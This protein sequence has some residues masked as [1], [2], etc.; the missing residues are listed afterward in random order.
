M[1]NKNI[2]LIITGGIAAYKS[3]DLIRRL[4]DAGANVRCI[5]TR[6]GAEFITPLSVASL[7]GHPVYSDLFS[8][9][10]EVEMGH[11]RLSRE[12]DLIIVA[13]ATAETIAKIAMGRADDLATT[14][15]LAANKPILIVP[16][17]NAQMWSNAATQSNIAQLR[18]RGIHQLGPNSG[19]LACGEIGD[20]RMAEVSEIMGWC[21]DY[22][23]HAGLLSGLKILVTAGPTMEPVDPVRFISNR[24]SGKQG[25]AIAAACAMAGAHVRIISGAPHLPA[26]ANC[27]IVPVETATQMMAACDA[28]LPVDVAICAAAVSDWQSRDVA[29]QKIKKAPG[30]TEMQIALVQTPD[31]LARL[32]AP[33]NRRPPLVIGF[34]AETENLLVNARAKLQNKSCDWILANDIGSNPAIMGGDHNQ[35]TLVDASGAESW[36]L[37]S[38]TELANKLVAK[39]AKK[40]KR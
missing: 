9:K 37:M 10:D 8:L 36:P 30:Q 27:E 40:F 16:S 17:M 34:A 18:A 23:A 13:P 12:S 14:T 25:Y 2:L 6:G 31:I 19:D 4:R 15:L 32:S 24:S 7:S 1:Q 33:S 21:R 28:A 5:L 3:L 29:A 11:I 38:K 26:P 22:F 35:V 39:I 20:G